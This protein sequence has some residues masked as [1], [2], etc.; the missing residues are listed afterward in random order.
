MKACISSWSYRKWFDE[1]RC[2]LLGLLDE[3]A[4]LKADGL[5]V[6]P[7]HVDEDRYAEQ[8]KEVARR[9]RA[10]KLEVTSLIV[11]NDFAVPAA[12]ARAEQVEKMTRAILAAAGARIKRLNVFTG[13][14][15]AGQDPAMEAARV[16]DGFREVCPLAEKK[17]VLLCLENHSSVARDV[18]GLLWIIRSIGSRA[19]RT[20]PDPTN[21][22]PRFSE[23]SEAE[24]EVIY[25]SAEQYAPNAAN[26][27][28]KIRDFT[29]SGEHAHCE[30]G[31]LAK[32]FRQAR[33]KGPV[34]LEYY[35]SGDPARPNE[36]GIRL[37]RKYFK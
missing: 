5:E 17:R 30:V 28:L 25:A 33:Y 9:A 14:H 11:G 1:G 12:A 10:M 13:H 4:R 3:A 19:M 27:H 34:V 29:R 15:T 2:D 8:L 31:R 24:R 37:L 7:A 23:R 6:F 21:F 26:A 36:R 20:N 35:G 22:C 32:I 16:I 18:D